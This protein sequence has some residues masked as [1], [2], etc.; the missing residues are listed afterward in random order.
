MFC[1]N[2]KDARVVKW[3]AVSH[4]LGQSLVNSSLHLLSV[5]IVYVNYLYMAHFIYLPFAEFLENKLC[6]SY[7]YQQI[8]P[9]NISASTLWQQYA[10][11]LKCST[12]NCL[13]LLLDSSITFRSHVSF[14]F[15]LHDFV[16]LESSLI[17]N[18]F[19]V[20][21]HADIFE[22]D[23]TLFHKTFPNLGLSDCFLMICFM[24]WNFFVRNITKV[25]LY[26]SQWYITG[27]V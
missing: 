7:L 10:I 14:L 13:C 19:F 4:H 5:Y 25:T 22:E 27:D 11:I 20:F 18:H 6:R 17:C 12:W 26:L 21:Y 15:F 2:W 24:L 8:F 23:S 3:D 1:P 16:F 9:K